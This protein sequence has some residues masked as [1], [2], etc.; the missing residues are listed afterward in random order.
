MNHLVTDL[1]R[2]PCPNC[3]QPTV[4]GLVRGW[5]ARITE[6]NLSPNQEAKAL[7]LGCNTYDLRITGK[8]TAVPRTTERI[9]YIVAGWLHAPDHSCAHRWPPLPEPA[10]PFIPNPDAEPPF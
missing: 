3:H 8:P 1:R 7:D 9:T 5:P 2:S 4:H 6:T 10:N